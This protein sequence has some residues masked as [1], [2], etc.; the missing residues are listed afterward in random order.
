MR[1]DFMHFLFMNSFQL[2]SGN[3]IFYLASIY[4]VLPIAAAIASNE[5]DFAKAH[6]IRA[7][8]SYGGDTYGAA[9]SAGA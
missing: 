1:I 8:L 6:N 4:Y 3:C 5:K 9:S 7:A 2:I